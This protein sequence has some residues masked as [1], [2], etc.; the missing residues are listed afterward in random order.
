MISYDNA[1][2]FKAKG[3]FIKNN[4]LLGYAMWEAGGDYNNILIDAINSAA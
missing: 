2:S 4:G 1:K 3:A